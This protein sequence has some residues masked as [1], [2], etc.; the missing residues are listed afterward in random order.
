MA[1]APAREQILEKGATTVKLTRLPRN[2]TIEALRQNLHHAVSPES[3]DYIYFPRSPDLQGKNMG[4]AFLNFVDHERALLCIEA[5]QTLPLYAE[6]RYYRPCT[7]S[8]ARL[9]GIGLN[10]AWLVA[11]YGRD[12]LDETTALH[13][14]SNGRTISDL[15]GVYEL[16][17]HPG[18]LE[19][20]KSLVHDLASEAAQAGE[21]QQ[22]QAAQKTQQ[23]NTIAYWIVQLLSGP[24]SAR[25]LSTHLVEF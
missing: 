12:V 10:L 16:H 11:K 2:F 9:Q 7:P 4:I 19:Y 1:A 20:A 15:R 24:V 14:F 6:R 18:M 13:I 23:Q 5:L 25:L 17:V 8:P 21:A 3:Y 22:G